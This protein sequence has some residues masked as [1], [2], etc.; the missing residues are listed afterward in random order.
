MYAGLQPV[1]W[2]WSRTAHMLFLEQ[3][4]HYL[5]KSHE[6]NPELPPGCLGIYEGLPI[7]RMG[8]PHAAVAAVACVGMR[9][10][11]PGF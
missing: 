3:L 7:Y 8:L 9:S 4:G 5:V 10:M 1:Q 6:P 11:P 2:H